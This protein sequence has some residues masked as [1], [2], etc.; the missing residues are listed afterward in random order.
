MI[1]VDASVLIAHLD[2]NDA[3]HARAQRVLEETAEFPL[4]ASGITL[5]EVLVGP[6][7]A[8]RLGAAEAALRDLEVGEVPV[9]A[10]AA[11]R[12]AELRADT[13]LKL[14]DCCV[15]LAAQEVAA[16]AVLTFDDRLAKRARDLGY[17]S[18][19]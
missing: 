17:G 12:L 13:G 10:G 19:T 11:G 6:A 4:A 1:I 8:G 15:L 9:P 5:A 2:R 16:E 3:L 18:D 7:R 14:P